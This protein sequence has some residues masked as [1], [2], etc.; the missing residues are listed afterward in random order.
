MRVTNDRVL[1]AHEHR[2]DVHEALL[3]SSVSEHGV[4]RLTN[5]GERELVI[6]SDSVDA[7]SK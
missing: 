7:V 3:I 2:H 1:P 4:V 6:L 5:G